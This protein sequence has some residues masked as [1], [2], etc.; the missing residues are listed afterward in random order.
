MTLTYKF[1][2]DSAYCK[3][4]IARYYRQRPLYIRLPVQFAV[5][6]LTAALIWASL[7]KAGSFRI[8]AMSLVI[9]GIAIIAGVLLLTSLVKFGVLRKLKRN[10]DFGAEVTLTISEEG[11]VAS[12]SYGQKRAAWSAYPDSVRFSDGILLLRG[13]AIRWLPDSALCAG[14]A[15]QANSLV[16]SKTRLR[17]LT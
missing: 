9:A 11:V 10:R 1:A 12:S 8:D 15:E 2:F 7:K 13:G 14:T 16:G 5:L 3:A 17:R 4:V 6:M